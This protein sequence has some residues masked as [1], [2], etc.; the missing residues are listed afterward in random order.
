RRPDREWGQNPNPKYRMT[1]IR[2]ELKW[3]LTTLQAGVKPRMEEVRPLLP[4][5]SR[6]RSRS[7]MSLASERLE[8]KPFV[9][10]GSTM[11]V[12]SRVKTP[13]IWHR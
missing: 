9:T 2:A 11:P 5:L 10:R 8:E 3:A 6:I 4:T 1:W 13:R 7:E 12:I